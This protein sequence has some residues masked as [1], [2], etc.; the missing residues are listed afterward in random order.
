VTLLFAD[1][2]RS[3][4]LIASLEAAAAYQLLGDVMDCLTAAVM[5]HDG[6][7]IDYYG[8]GLAAMW[9]APADQV[10]HV[11]LACR[12]ALRMLET[13]PDV[14]ADWA[15]LL[16]ADLQLAIGVHTGKA[17]VGNAGARRRSKY[18]PR[19]P[20]VHLTSRVE[21]ASKELQVPLVVTRSTANRLSNRFKTHRLCRA[22]LRGAEQP[23]DLFAISKPT[24][25][26]TL[27][28]DWA[29]YETALQLFE[30]GKCAE[31][32]RI[33]APLDQQSST[34]P[35]RFLA[36]EIERAIGKQ[37]RRRNTDRHASHHGIVTLGDR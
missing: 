21:A 34:V 15:D 2:R 25:S 24:A 7:V 37:Q 10:E 4:Q 20:A 31:A 11:E 27:H 26:E 36:S 13:L 16:S 12:A 33:L 22:R 17:I 1:L 18:G 8:D 3:T 19:G 30:Q 6:L 14:T 35:V 5:D 9:N 23:V 32:A 28:A 29:S